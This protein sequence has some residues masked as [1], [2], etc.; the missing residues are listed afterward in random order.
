MSETDVMQEIMIEATR[1]GHRLHRN[2]VGMALFAD[3]R[4]NVQA[5]KYGVGGKGGSDLIGFT[6][7]LYFDDARYAVEVPV[8]TVVETKAA[9]GRK[10]EKQQQF[11]DYVLAAGGVAGFCYSVKDYHK[12][13]GY[14]EG[15]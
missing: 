15:T 14:S 1:L 4:G 5:V 3:A 6:R 9:R 8:F 7:K 2:N 13:I 12:L 11:I 10:R